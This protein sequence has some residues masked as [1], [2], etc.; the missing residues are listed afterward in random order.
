MLF[1][2]QGWNLGQYI[3]VNIGTFLY[4]VTF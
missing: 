2:L 1:P 3:S 4:I